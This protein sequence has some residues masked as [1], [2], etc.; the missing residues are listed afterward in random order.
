[1]LIL[2][3]VHGI[4]NKINQLLDN[5]ISLSK[6]QRN[7]TVTDYVFFLTTT[8]LNW[9]LMRISYLENLPKYLK[10]KQHTSK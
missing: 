10:I 9:K 7:E 3:S 1:M 8:K 6:F 4:F 2:W 5:E